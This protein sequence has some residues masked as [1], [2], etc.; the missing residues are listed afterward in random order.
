[1]QRTATILAFFFICVNSFAQQSFSAQPSSSNYN[2]KHV[3]VQNG[4]VYNIVYHFLQDSY[5]Y[6]WIGTHNGLTLYDG[7]RT[8]NFLH[9]EEEKTSI[10]GTFITSIF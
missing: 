4:L 8:T 3:N 2:F 10:A 5:G 7:I 9:N 6:M 1:M